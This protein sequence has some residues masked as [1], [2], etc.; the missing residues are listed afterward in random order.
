MENL[1]YKPDWPEARQ[2]LSAWWKGEKLDRCMLQLWA[3]RDGAKLVPVPREP[4]TLEQRW[5]DL[6]YLDAV[7]EYDFQTTFFGAEAL[8]VWSSGFPGHVALPTFYGCPFQLSRTTGWHDPILTG[9]KLDVSHLRVD[10]QSRWWKFGDMLLDHER[11][12]TA[13]KSIPSMGAIFGC[14]DTLAMLRGNERMLFDLVDDPA[15]VREAELKLMDDWID[16]HRHHVEM[17]TRDGGPYATWF[18]LWAPGKYYVTQCDVSYGISAAAFRECFV[19]ALRK[20]MEYLDYS[21][22]H[23]DGEGAFHLV[24]EIAS[25]GKINAIQILPG[26]GKPSP[27]HYLDVLR[28]VQRLG[29]GLHIGIPP[30]E[31]E[32]ALSLLSSRGLFLAVS[33]NSEKQAREV[34][35]LCGRKSVDRG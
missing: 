32:T 34:I 24:D 14:G 17:L 9:E 3:P 10:R 23:C 1:L 5:T 27:L 22:Y 28:K 2:R 33:C 19:P 20:Q 25:I 16:V 4:E 12:V 29:K 35:D 26:A 8:P 21:I 30:E 11:R 31:V 6:D 7:N 18:G 13:G 15:A